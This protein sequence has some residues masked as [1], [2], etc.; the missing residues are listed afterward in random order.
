VSW[1][2]RFE[3]PIVLEDGTKLTTLRQAVEYLV[4]TVRTASR[5]V[6]A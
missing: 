2:R 6:E 1:S 5:Q 3:E 4:R